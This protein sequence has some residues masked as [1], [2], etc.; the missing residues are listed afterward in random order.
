MAA[1][2]TVRGALRAAWHLPPDGCTRL[3]GGMTS[4]TWSVQAA[5]RSYVAK[6]VPAGD[7]TAF[8]AGLSI[9]ERLSAVGI[10]AGRPI[11]AADGALC[12]PLADGVLALLE[13]VPGRP[14]DA[15][16]PC[17]G[18]FVYD[19]AS[20]IMYAGGPDRAGELLE[21]YAAAGPVPRAELEAALPVLLR[22][23]WAV[24]ADWFARRI[25]R[26]DETGGDADANRAGLSDAR[27]ALA[28][29]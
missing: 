18:P 9:A 6:L 24:Q 2:I 16:D 25:A 10:P 23:R 15:A 1:D 19:V 12:V 13:H 11:R 14:L 27:A 5:G 22:F 8:E 28:A 17:A 20:A 21:A 7:R 29:L 4:T 26:G 3:A